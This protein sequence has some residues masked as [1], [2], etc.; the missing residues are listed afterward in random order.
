MILAGDVG[1]TK[2]LLAI[3]VADGD[4]YRCVNKQRYVLYR[5]DID[6]LF[7]EIPV[8]FQTTAVGTLNN[9][10]YQDVAYGQY[11]GVTVLKPLE[12]LYFDY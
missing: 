5:Q 2:T 6:T 3:Y 1:G 10:N 4:S 7:M 12:V 8:D 11:A 9:F